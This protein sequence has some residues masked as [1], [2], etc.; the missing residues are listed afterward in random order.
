MSSA[1]QNCCRAQLSRAQPSPSA[2]AF[3]RG[4]KL[5][6]H[7]V[8]AERYN[9]S[10]SAEPQSLEGCGDAAAGSCDSGPPERLLEAVQ[11]AQGIQRAQPADTPLHLL[12]RASL[13]RSTCATRTPHSR[14]SGAQ[15]CPLGLHPAGWPAASSCGCV[16]HCQHPM[17]LCA[18]TALLFPQGCHPSH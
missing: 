3:S 11:P 8:K 7:V 13:M 2:R 14:V 12:S 16:A 15:A 4:W 18:N 9:P 10:N 5:G 1:K 6:A 17:G